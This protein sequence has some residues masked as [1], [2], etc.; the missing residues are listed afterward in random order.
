MEAKANMGILLT[1]E[2]KSVVRE[3]EF[4]EVGQS[5]DGQ[6]TWFNKTSANTR[7]C[8]DSV[9]SSVTIFW[10]NT[11]AQLVSKTFRTV[12]SLSD[13]LTLNPTR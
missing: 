9:T 4:V 10:E 7:L 2:F 12:T 3:N 1:T 6:T 11:Q 8:I 5:E 13:W